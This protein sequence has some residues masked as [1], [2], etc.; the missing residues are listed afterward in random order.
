MNITEED[1]LNHDLK[2]LEEKD[3]ENTWPSHETGGPGTI[4]PY[5]I[6]YA[7]KQ[8]GGYEMMRQIARMGDSGVNIDNVYDGSVSAGAVLDQELYSVASVNV[9]DAVGNLLQTVP[10][11]TDLGQIFSYITDPTG[12]TGNIWWMVQPGGQN[13]V[14]GYT[15]VY[16]PMLK[17]T[18]TVSNLAF[19]QAQAN[20]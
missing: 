20:L 5:P 6:Q 3:P 7:H 2:R 19:L 11:N 18:L 14:T 16:V 9:Y 1:Q 4:Q 12:A 15:Y 10:A 8:F 17:G 13:Y